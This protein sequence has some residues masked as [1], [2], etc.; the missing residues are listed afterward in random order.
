MRNKIA[1]LLAF[2][3]LIVFMATGCESEETFSYHMSATIDGNQWRTLMPAT[4]MQKDKYVITGTSLNGKVLTLTIMGNEPGTY[5]F[6]KGKCMAVYKDSPTLSDDDAF[7]SI[8]GEIFLTEV[9]EE[10]KKLSG[11]FSFK[12]IKKEDAL[13]PIYIEQGVFDGIKYAF[14]NND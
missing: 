12:M 11:T 10:N 14:G 13:N 7:A 6:L 5:S 1:K 9:D 4:V 8:S 3:G 2:T